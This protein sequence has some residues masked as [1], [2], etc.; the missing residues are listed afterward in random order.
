MCGLDG[1]FAAGAL[2]FWLS[3]AQPDNAKAAATTVIIIIFIA[4]LF[5]FL[6]HYSG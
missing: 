4:T 1:F 5:L 6:I 3:V 2:A